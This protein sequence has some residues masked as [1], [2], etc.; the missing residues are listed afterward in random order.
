MLHLELLTTLIG[1]TKI[2]CSFKP[3]NK[4]SINERKNVFD[5]LLPSSIVENTHN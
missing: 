2:A 4:K 5:I 3:P 1:T